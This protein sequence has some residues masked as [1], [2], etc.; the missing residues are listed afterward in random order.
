MIQLRE[1]GILPFVEGKTFHQ[2]DDV[3]GDPPEYCVPVTNMTGKEA[4]LAAARFY[5]LAFRTIASSTN[6][7]TAIFTILPPGV[8]SSNSALPEASPGERPTS[9]AL[10]ITA[11]TNSFSFDWLLRQ[12]VSANITFNFLDAVPVPNMQPIRRFLVHTAVRL[13]CN[14]IGYE[15]LW[16]EQMG[17]A[18]REPTLPC[19]WPVLSGDAERLSVRA[20]ID[21][22]VARSYNLDRA[23]YDYI[24]STFS[25]SSYPQAPDLCLAAFDEL[26][27]IGLEAFC[28]KYDPY[29]DILLNNSLPQPV[30]NLPIPGEQQPTGRRGP[31]AN[32]S[33][34]YTLFEESLGPLFD[35]AKKPDRK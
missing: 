26:A 16:K 7:R 2:Y 10:A 29:W 18:W 34:Q 4:R 32:R 9:A 35:S 23:Q 21:A 14:H 27:E 25:H 30:I 5:R 33:G 19:I 17:D 13:V 12:L 22:V 8:L 31:V 28:K 24:L 15:P 20:C 11:L 3:W 1:Q 6:E